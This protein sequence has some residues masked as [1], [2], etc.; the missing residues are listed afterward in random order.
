MSFLQKSFVSDLLFFSSSMFTL[1]DIFQTRLQII[2]CNFRNFSPFVSAHNLFDKS[3]QHA[4]ILLDC[5]FKYVRWMLAF[6]MHSR[7]LIDCPVLVRRSIC[8]LTCDLPVFLEASLIGRIYTSW[9]IV[10]EN[11]WFF[12]R[13]GHISCVLDNCV[14]K[15]MCLP[16]VLY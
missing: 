7:C 15:L 3:P 9:S 5:F 6:V 14:M 13:L 11:I 10:D 1:Q 16:V 4:C 12:F 8:Q 2:E